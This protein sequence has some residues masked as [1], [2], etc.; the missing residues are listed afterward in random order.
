[1]KMAVRLLGL[2]VSE[3]LR[4]YSEHQARSHLARFDHD[5]SSVD[6]RIRDI[7]G[8]NGGEEKHCQVMRADR[9]LA[10]PP[11]RS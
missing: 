8:P 6:I 1:M 9:D 7:N 5:L 11:W 2:P 10:S 3:A 4:E